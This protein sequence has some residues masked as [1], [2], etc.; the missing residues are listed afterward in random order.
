MGELQ[1][2]N[3]R[4]ELALKEQQGMSHDTRKGRETLPKELSEIK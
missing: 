2:S 3:E 4:K 1:K